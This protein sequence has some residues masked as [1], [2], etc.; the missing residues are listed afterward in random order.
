ME[1]FNYTDNG[2][3]RMSFIK[4]PIQIFTIFPWNS[5]FWIRIEESGNINSKGYVV[6]KGVKYF[7]FNVSNKKNY[8]DSMATSRLFMINSRHDEQRSKNYIVPNKK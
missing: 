1:N 6:N 7:F 5:G 3:I 4:T 8:F 2:L